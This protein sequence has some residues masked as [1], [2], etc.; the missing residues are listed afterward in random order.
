[1]NETHTC[2]QWALQSHSATNMDNVCS[3][4]S[5]LI[6][7]RICLVRLEISRLSVRFRTTGLQTPKEVFKV[8]RDK[9]KAQAERRRKARNTAAGRERKRAEGLEPKEVWIH[10]SRDADLRKAVAKLQKP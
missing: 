10:P 7:A 9:E 6:G 8:S 3:P 2:L 4:E 5:S 1:M